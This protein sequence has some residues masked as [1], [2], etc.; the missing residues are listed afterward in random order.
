MPTVRVRGVDLY[1]EEH[2]S[3]PHLVVA[4]GLMASVAT[5]HMFGERIEDIAARGV[6]VIAYDARGH[7]RSGYTARRQDYHWRALAEDMYA[8]I[9][10]LGLGRAAVYG[11]S[12]GAATALLLALEHPDAVDKLILRVPPPFDDEG[13]RPVRRVF[14]LL[15][16][17][18]ML[19]GPSRTARLVTALPAQRKFQRE[20]PGTDMRSFFGSQ[21]RPAIVAAIRG[22]L[23]DAPQLPLH[24]LADIEHPTLILTH[25]D[26]PLHPLASGEL[27]HERM[28]HAK[29]AVAPT[30]SY[31]VAHRD[32]LAHVIASFVK[33]ETVA[34]G[35][36]QKVL[37][38][39]ANI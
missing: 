37:H 29:L 13:S 25:P 24:R 4:H 36:P 27:L 7:G 38:E 39:H 17:S 3:G 26:D 20:H 10:A 9:R 1:Y 5:S 8:L 11:G 12:I 31:W 35:L 6:H 15:A 19:L 28:P 23:L 21:R 33:G 30:P 2:G 34:H 18:Y 32:A 22:A 16:L 14:S